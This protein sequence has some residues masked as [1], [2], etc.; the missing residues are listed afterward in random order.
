MR[1]YQI[2]YTRNAAGDIPNLKAASF[3]K[4]AQAMVGVPL[5]NSHQAP[6]TFE[7]LQSNLAGVYSYQTPSGL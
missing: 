7:K 2:V 5:E 4:K 6:P 1:L 3:G